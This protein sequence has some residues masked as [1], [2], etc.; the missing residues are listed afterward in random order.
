MEIKNVKSNLK[1]N[2]FNIMMICFISLNGLFNEYLSILSGL[3]FAVFILVK[4]KAEGELTLKI[5]LTSIAVFGIV[6]F[7]GLSAFWAVDGGSAVLGFA[8]FLPILLFLILIIANPHYKDFLNTLP[9]FAAAMTLISALLMQ[10]DA[11]EEYFS[12]AGRLSGFF[13]YSNTFALF[14]LVSLITLATKGKIEKY[15]YLYFP[16][17]IFGILYSGSRTVFV[18]T[19]LTVASF[20]FL[21]KNKKIK[22]LILGFFA[23]S[24][25]AITAV[26]LFADENSVFGRFLTISLSQ[27]TFVGRFLYFYDA[28]PIILKH[29]FG[30]GYLGYCFMQQSIQTGVYSVRFIHNDFLQLL[31]DIGW[32]PTA[33]FV[34]AVVKS[35]F[36]KGTPLKCRL[37]L[38]VI[39]AHAC[40]DF[41]LQFIAVFMIFIAC[42]DTESG[43]EIK[44]NYMKCALPLLCVTS[45]FMLY[46][47][48]PQTLLAFGDIETSYKM[49]PFSDE[50]KIEM[51][52]QTEDIEDVNRIADEI[53]EGNEC[54]SLAYS[55]KSRYYYSLGD[56]AN[57][58]RYK[59]LAIEY[60]PFSTEEYE[61]YLYMLLI[62]VQLY[63]EAGDSDS[64]EYCKDQLL[65]VYDDFKN[66]GTRL[67]TLGK[68][69]K[70]QPNFELSEELT[71]CL[72]EMAL[73]NEN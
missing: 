50:T 59:D 61:D 44:I 31:L 52:T 33:V 34:A 47:F 66:M 45:A 38:F 55:A 22:Y 25:L 49:Y 73:E 18:L 64:A 60:A 53:L 21:I 3:V 27:S 39:S 6:L 71:E 16:I 67:S 5:G 65:A 36:K 48:I 23:L 54:V 35:F 15:E 57:M 62:G 41:D 40:F 9:P 26:V 42:M 56:F 13:Q 1:D 28:L 63:G 58:M 12:V 46:M 14:L 30:T 17:I 11:F 51:L 2:I 68:K 7:Y 4:F 72:N 37:I 29:P 19:A 10:F 43:K 70:D 8:K 24:V 69:I 20:V 32:I